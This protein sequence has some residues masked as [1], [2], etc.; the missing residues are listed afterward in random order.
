MLMVPPPPLLLENI[1]QD[2]PNC[3]CDTTTNSVLNLLASVFLLTV[4]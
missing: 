2:P 3:S 4:S 1:F